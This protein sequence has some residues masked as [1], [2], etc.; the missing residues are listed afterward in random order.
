[1]MGTDPTPIN[2]PRMRRTRSAPMQPKGAVPLPTAL[3]ALEELLHPPEKDVVCCRAGERHRHIGD[4]T[5]RS[6]Q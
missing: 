4:G 1:M 5:W 3:T 2:R 6:S